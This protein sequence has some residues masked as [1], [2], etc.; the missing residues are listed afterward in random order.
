MAN[1]WEGLAPQELQQGSH[2]LFKAPVKFTQALACHR[3]WIQMLQLGVAT[4]QL[5]TAGRLQPWPWRMTGTSKSQMSALL[6]WLR[7]GRGMLVSYS[8]AV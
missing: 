5:K 7:P 3:T 6:F 8:S 4:L 1:M 2:A